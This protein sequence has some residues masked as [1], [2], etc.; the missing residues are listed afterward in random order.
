[1]SELKMQLEQDSISFRPGDQIRGTIVWQLEN[2]PSQLELL[3]FWRTEGKGTQD[4]GVAETLRFENP[5]PSGTQH[6]QIKAPAGPY[7]FSGRLISILWA[8]ELSCPGGTAAARKDI[9]IS[10]SGREIICTQSIPDPAMAAVKGLMGRLAGKIAQGAAAIPG[11]S[12]ETV[13]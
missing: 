6:F 2:A 8:M 1:M 11:S 7:S 9:V 3:L 12:D 13:R 10:P 5:G 4:I